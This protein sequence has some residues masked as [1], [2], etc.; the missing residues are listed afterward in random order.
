MSNEIW[1]PVNGYE[2][3]YMVSNMGNVFSMKTAQLLRFADVKGYKRVRLYTNSKQKSFLVHRLVAIAFIN[4]PLNKPTVNHL[5]ENTS[6]NRA[7]NLEWATQQENNNYGSR[8][9]KMVEKTDYAARVKH[10]NN[11]RARRKQ[12]KAVI[13]M[14][15]EGKPIARF[16]SLSAAAKSLGTVYQNIIY[17]CSKST[18]TLKG[19]RFVYDKEGEDDYDS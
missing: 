7:T 9:A 5:N 19:Y 10:P 17:A 16:E 1:K 6:D 15:H 11:Q 3:A 13:Q 12:M 2:N 14:N 8:I 18:H 4:N